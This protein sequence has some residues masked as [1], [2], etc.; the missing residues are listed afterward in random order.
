MG[1]FLSVLDRMLEIFT[2]IA[3]AIMLLLTVSQVLLRYVFN[4]PTSWSEEITLFLLVWFGFISMSIGVR[5]NTHISLEFF[6]DRLG[7]TGKFIL[8]VGRYLLLLTFSIMMTAYAFPMIAIGHTNTMPSTQISRAVLYAPA[9][10]G[11]ALMMLFSLLNLIHVFK[12]RGSKH[13]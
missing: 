13:V 1:K 7:D 10:V 11:G 2:V 8:D 5:K 4:N 6:Y 9:L 12:R 3:L